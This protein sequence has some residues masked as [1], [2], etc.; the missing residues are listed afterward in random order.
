MKIKCN[1]NTMKDEFN[2]VVNKLKGKSA[3][4][5]DQIPEFIVNLFST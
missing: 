4:G 5:F 3:T 1:S 2:Q